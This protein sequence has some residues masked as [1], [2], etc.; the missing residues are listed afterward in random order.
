[1]AKYTTKSDQSI[2]DLSNQLYGNASSAIKILTD[3]P[4]LAGITA[5]IAA[6]SEIEYTPSVGNSVSSFFSDN[7]TLV[8]TGSGNPEQGR[9]FDLGF[10]LTGLR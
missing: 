1:M 6:G 10:S 8:T 2:W 3:N 9:G 7:K 5:K 4:T